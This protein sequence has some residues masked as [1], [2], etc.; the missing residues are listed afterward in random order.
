LKREKSIE[1]DVK[2]KEKVVEKEKKKDK[3]VKSEIKTKRMK[4]I[5]TYGRFYR[6]VR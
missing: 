1:K 4:E 2:E 3:D 5:K 6:S